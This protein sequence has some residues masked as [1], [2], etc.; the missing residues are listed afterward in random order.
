[1]S[2]GDEVFNSRV[3][4]QC[5]D[6]W[7]VRAFGQPY[8]ARLAAEMFLVVFD[9]YV[10]LSPAR[11]FSRDQREKPVRGAARNDLYRTFIL[12]F[13]KCADEVSP[14]TVVPKSERRTQAFR[15][16][17]RYFMKFRRLFVR[18]VRFFVS[19]LEQIFQMASVS[20]LEKFVGEHL[21]QRRRDIHRKPRFHTCFV[22]IL[23]NENKRKVNLSYRFVEP[24]F[25]EELGIFGMPDKRQVSVKD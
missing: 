15:V 21:A 5:L 9:S 24:I 19:E 18:S 1:M 11:L 6:P 23:K 17:L 16:H 14:V 10:D 20:G 7:F 3:F 8:P 13:A 25:F 4:Q 22:E 12:K 2:V